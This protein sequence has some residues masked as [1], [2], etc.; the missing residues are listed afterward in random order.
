LNLR[1]KHAGTCAGLLGL[2]LVFTVCSQAAAKMIW[3]PLTEALLRIDDRA[4]KQ[5]NLYHSGKKYDPLLLQLGARMLVIYIRNQSVYELSPAKL[6]HKGE[7][8]LWSETDK[9]EKPLDTSDWSTRDIGFA[10]RVRV[11]LAGEG[12][13]I[14]IQIPESVDFRGFY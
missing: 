3:K 4:P 8:L 12:R 2:L 11:N 13:V 9:P 7:N 6:E 1:P 10:W 14:D 5:W